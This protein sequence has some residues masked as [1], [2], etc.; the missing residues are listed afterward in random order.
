MIF[1]KKNKTKEIKCDLDKI[2]KSVKKLDDLEQKR[3]RIKKLIS[4][5]K[6]NIK[7]AEED[8][9]ERAEEQKSRPTIDQKYDHQ[10]EGLAQDEV[11]EL[12]DLGSKLDTYQKEV[13]DVEQK[14][15]LD[16][17]IELLEEES[18]DIERR[19]KKN[20]DALKDMELETLKVRLEHNSA[21]PPISRTK[22]GTKWKDILSVVR[23]L[24]GWLIISNGNHQ[25]QIIFPNASRPIPISSDVGDNA[26][27][28]DVKG[29]LR[30]SM[31]KEKIPNGNV[32]M[33]A[34]KCGDLRLVI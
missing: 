27:A 10:I 13:D 5:M 16:A 14:E 29:Q 28:N 12:R 20:E 1:W 23:Q 22:T 30:Y 11:A 33:K 9:K 17:A 18:K 19:E 26:V 34:F 8:I 32:L 4:Q 2:H 25:A 21:Q 15:D 24:G 3:T 7:E 6:D 31:P